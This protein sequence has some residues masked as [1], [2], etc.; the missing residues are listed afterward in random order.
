MLRH[1]RPRVRTV[2]TERAG[3]DR[4]REV[5]PQGGVLTCDPVARGRDEPGA[6]GT[7]GSGAVPASESDRPGKF[8]R[9][10]IYVLVCPW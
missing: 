10:H 6:L 8:A 1:R 5:Q 3:S 4:L 7:G 2:R 9:E